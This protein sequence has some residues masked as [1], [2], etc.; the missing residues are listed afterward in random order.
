MH[1]QVV[2]CLYRDFDNI[3]EPHGHHTLDVERKGIPA[4]RVKWMLVGNR[5]GM[6]LTPY[7]CTLFVG[8]HLWLRPGWKITL[9]LVTDQTQN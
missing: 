5:V 6:D 8:Q 3:N 9:G 2:H 4:T 7:G 1:T